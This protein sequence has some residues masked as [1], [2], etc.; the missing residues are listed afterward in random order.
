MA[1]QEMLMS[2][3]AMADVR[4]K[5]VPTHHF[6]WSALLQNSLFYL[7]Y[8]GTILVIELLLLSIV[9]RLLSLLSFMFQ[10]FYFCYLS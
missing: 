9:F 5:C 4:S 6:P 3:Q 8:R 1:S 7:C 2:D 10:T